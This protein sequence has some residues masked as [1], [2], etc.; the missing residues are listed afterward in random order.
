MAM[1]KRLFWVLV[2]WLGLPGDFHWWWSVGFPVVVAAVIDTIFFFVRDAP[3]WQLA[4]TFVIVS[5]VVFVIAS[6]WRTQ[7]QEQPVVSHPTTYIENVHIGAQGQ[8]KR[9]TTAKR[10]AANDLLGNALKE[11]ESLKQGRSYAL[12]SENQELDDIEIGDEYQ[13]SYHEEVRGW[14]D[15]TYDLIG[16]AFGRAAAQ[17]F[18]SNE[19]YTDQELFGRKLPSFLHVSSTQRKY[20]LRARLKRLHELTEQMHN[21]D[22]NP[23]FDPDEWRNR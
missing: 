19:G 10:K 15:H 4:L 3:Y 22:I 16:A 13:A 2:A 18:I 14:V 21:L 11:G 7:Q 1:L 17:R 23:G 9:E 5:F 6:R 20:S 12:E 8:E